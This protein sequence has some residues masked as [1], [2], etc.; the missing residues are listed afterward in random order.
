MAKSYL[1]IATSSKTL[2]QNTLPIAETLGLENVVV[3]SPEKLLLH[4]RSSSPQ[5]I[6]IDDNLVAD[7]TNHDLIAL[8]R[9][10]D[11]ITN[12]PIICLG[13]KDPKDHLARIT[14]GADLCLGLPI[15]SELLKAYLQNFLEKTT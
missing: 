12:V 3:N 1:L 4:L 11:N 13:L 2:S 7:T 9:R 15:Q 10:R 14:S 5:A 6:I 8:L